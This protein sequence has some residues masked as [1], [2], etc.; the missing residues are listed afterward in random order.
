[1]KVLVG[2][3]GGVDSTVTAILLKEAGY[4]V[5][6]ATMAIWG[7]RNIKGIAQEHKKKN[8]CFGPD[9]KED[10]ESAKKVAAEIGVPYHV[11]NCAKEYDEVVL[12]YFKSEYLKGKTPNPCVYCNALIKFGV[13]PHIARMN[14]V[15]FD[16][17]ATGHYAKVE[18]Q[19][20]RYVLKRGINP[21]KD[22]SYFLYKLTQ[23]Q[24]ANIILPLGN[25]NKEQ[26]RDIAQKHGLSVADKHDSQDFYCGDYNELL[27]VENKKGNIVDTNGKILGEHEG[28][29]N[30][31]IG[32]R[33]GLGISSTE[34]LYVLSLNKDTNEVV[35]GFKDKTFK[36]SLTAVDINF[37]S[38]DKLPKDKQLS[39]KIRST[40]QPQSVCAEFKDNKLIVEFDEWQKSIAPGQ[41]VV[42]YD[43]DIV[44]AG[45]IIDTVE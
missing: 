16:K 37:V 2:M 38:Y 19:N 14:G 31:T 11:F 10:I 20:G 24:L 29:W 23:E 32:Q 42:I 30:Y 9:E 6:G 22:Q 40:Q 15:T 45:G 28:I 34:P 25:Y 7:D 33:K 26:I 4:D 43:D 12:K 21:H 5:I 8:A 1:M 3:S 17:F 27:E 44:V 39:A 41:S 18:E 36:K 13:L 35:V